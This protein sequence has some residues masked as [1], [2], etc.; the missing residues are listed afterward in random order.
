MNK[1]HT[2]PQPTY[3]AIS[4]EM[5]RALDQLQRI[6]GHETN[7]ILAAAYGLVFQKIIDHCGVKVAEEIA[8]NSACLIGRHVT[9]TEREFEKTVH[10]CVVL[11]LHRCLRRLHYVEQIPVR[12]ILAVMNG[13]VIAQIAGFFGGKV[14][15]EIVNKA[16]SRVENLAPLPE[17]EAVL[18]AQ[19]GLM[20]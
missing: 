3:E 11:E 17:F 13:E 8:G 9:S 2:I 7:E 14:T 20:Q 18:A 10:Q 19:Q 1:P 15:A 5:N 4:S 16:I 12:D 6:Q